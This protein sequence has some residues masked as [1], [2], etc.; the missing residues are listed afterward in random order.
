MQRHVGVNDDRCHPS[1]CE[2][3]TNELTRFVLACNLNPVGDP[4]LGHEP[5]ILPVATLKVLAFLLATAD[6]VFTLMRVLLQPDM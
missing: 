2:G 5:Q 6:A 1:P 4:L 3:K